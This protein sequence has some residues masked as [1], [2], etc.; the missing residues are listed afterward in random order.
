VP[1]R[2]M[3]ALAMAIE[4][5][6][7]A[8]ASVGCTPALP[9]LNATGKILCDESTKTHVACTIR[10]MSGRLEAVNQSCILAGSAY[11]QVRASGAR[12]CTTEA[13]I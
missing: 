3:P 5:T 6:L 2:R 11:Y 12:A 4:R 9:A 8:R 1:N 7:D 13:R 10:A